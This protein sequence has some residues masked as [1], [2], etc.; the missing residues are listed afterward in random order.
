MIGVIIVAHGRLAIEYV[1]TVEHV[2]GA[3]VNFEAITIHPDDDRAAKE[4][5]ICT[6]ANRL[7][8]GDGVVIVTDMFGG[9]PS[10]LSLQ[11]CRPVNRHI[12]YGANMPMLIKLAQSRRKPI[13]EAVAAA[14]FAGR[15]YI[16]SHDVSLPATAAEK[17]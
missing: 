6:T 1:N 7:D 12:L 8:D 5:E 4:A 13:A 10:N 17:A 15:K 9:S 11:A 3:Q 14:L 2:T 16:D